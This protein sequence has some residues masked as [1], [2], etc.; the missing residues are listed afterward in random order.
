MSFQGDPWFK[1]WQHNILN[2]SGSQL[3][4]NDIWNFFTGNQ[5]NGHVTGEGD[6]KK[7]YVDELY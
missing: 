2:I 7:D 3:L 5:L 4:K 6:L 1:I